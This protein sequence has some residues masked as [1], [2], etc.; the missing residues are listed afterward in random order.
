[1]GSLRH[2]WIIFSV[3][4]AIGLAIGVFVVHLGMG[5]HTDHCPACKL[6][7]HTTALNAGVAA[8]TVDLRLVAVLDLPDCT[9]HVRDLA[10][11]SRP[12]APP[13]S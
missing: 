5:A 1:M 7:Q 2:N 3:A 6:S 11:H 8:P 12:R 4:I 10:A 9:A 13:T